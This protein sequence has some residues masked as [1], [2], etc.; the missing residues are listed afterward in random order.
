MRTAMKTRGIALAGRLALCAYAALIA[1]LSLTTQDAP[2]LGDWDKLAHGSAYLGFA[3]IALVASRNRR[4]HLVLCLVILL[5]GGL[6]ECLQGL[7]PPR[8]PSLFD[9]LANTLGVGA[10]LWLARW[11]PPLIAGEVV[12]GGGDTDAG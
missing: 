12:A 11:L 9:M 6:L 2:P 7:L 4:E 10:G 8:T 5:Y 1:W 3:L